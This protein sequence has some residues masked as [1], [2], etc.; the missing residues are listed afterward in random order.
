MASQPDLLESIWRENFGNLNFFFVGSPEVTVPPPVAVVED[1][2]VRVG[3]EALG[4]SWK[5]KQTY[6]QPIKITVLALE[7]N[8]I[9]RVTY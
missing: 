4:W 1:V 6:T 2:G 7:S 5:T 3:V 9:A 8:P